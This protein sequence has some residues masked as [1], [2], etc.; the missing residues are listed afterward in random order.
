MSDFTLP[1]EQDLPLLNELEPNR[2]YLAIVNYQGHVIHVVERS[3]LA[4]SVADKLK[5]HHGPFSKARNRRLQQAAH[6]AIMDF[7]LELMKL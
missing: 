1:H 7:F 2:M 6:E 5:V 4:L 3:E